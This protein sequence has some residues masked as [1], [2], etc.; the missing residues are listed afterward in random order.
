MNRF[1]KPTLK[2]LGI[3][4]MFVGVAVILSVPATWLWG[5]YERRGLEDDFDQELVSSLSANHDLLDQLEGE[6]EREKIRQLAQASQGQLSSEQAIALLEIPKIGVNAIVVEGTGD[7][8]LRKGV[9]HLEETPLPGLA[10]NFALAGDRVLWGGPF[11]NLDDLAAGD[12]ITV[13]TTYAQF[14][15]AVISSII[16]NPE[17][18]SVLGGR[19]VDEITLITCDPPWSTSHRLIIKGE[20]VDF[21]LND[22]Q[23]A[24]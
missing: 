7:G 24:T 20:L 1:Y 2:K 3:L 8:S 18:T 6:A 11:L 5:Y 15:Y 22:Q 10:G 23:P 19:G 16:T 9:G 21:K 4:L 14:S 17:D 13:K 12:T